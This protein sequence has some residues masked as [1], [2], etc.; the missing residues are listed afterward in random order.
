MQAGQAISD[1][2]A[3]IRQRALPAWCLSFALHLAL[4]VSAMLLWIG[5]PKAQRSEELARP[6]AIVLAQRSPDG[7]H[8]YFAEPREAADRVSEDALALSTM[9]TA[10]IPA[11]ELVV[12]A[13]ALPDAAAVSPA[14]VIPVDSRQLTAGGRRPKL[15]GQDQ[16]A[17]IAAEQA[18][19]RESP[20]RGPTTQISLFGGPAA[21]GNSFVFL[22]DRSQSMGSDGLNVLPDAQ[23][24][25][26]R[27][28]QPLG[29]E[30]Y[31]QVVVYHDKT[32]YLNQRS[33]LPATDDNKRAVAGFLATK[34]ALGATGHEGALL[35]VLR[36]EPDV[37]FL[38]TDGGDPELKD[39]Q[40]RSLAKIAG[41]HTKICCLH[42]GAG[43]LQQPGHFLQRLAA[44]TGGEYG[45][46]DV[47]A[48]RQ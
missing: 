11:G 29:T 4:L 43:P 3:A 23:Q 46:I 30:Q 15:P 44:L 27:A 2:A 18:R 16:A 12:P 33:L 24:E 5:A 10:D 9:N 17:F 6:A 38:L 28:L 25:L 41:G 48:R 31:F 45:Y 21:V 37:I 1:A 20:R 26:L 22:I 40:L 7:Q 32:V 42:F 34:A 8:E 14:G 35:S 36:L 19:L 47:S 13:F 39:H